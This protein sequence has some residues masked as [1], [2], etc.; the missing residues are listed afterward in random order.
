MYLFSL[1]VNN[2]NRSP[3]VSNDSQN[4]IN[5]RRRTTT[6]YELTKYILTNNSVARL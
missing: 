3:T 5:C 1:C 4:G 6:I 2:N